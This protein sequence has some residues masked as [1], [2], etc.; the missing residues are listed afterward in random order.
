MY[1]RCSKALCFTRI[2]QSGS[3]IKNSFRR[4]MSG[5]KESA[6][7]FKADLKKRLSPIQYHV[8]QEKGTERWIWPNYLL[9]TGR[10]ICV[11]CVFQ[12]YFFPRSAGGEWEGMRGMS[13]SRRRNFFRTNR[14]AEILLKKKKNVYKIHTHPP[15]PPAPSRGPLF[16]TE[17]LTKA[18]GRCWGAH[19]VLWQKNVRWPLYLFCR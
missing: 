17:P 8:T 16:K 11:K 4:T 5:E 10:V 7:D 3:K 1:C 6:T 12:W 18:V 9:L 19:W 13:S 15:S 14:T 2:V